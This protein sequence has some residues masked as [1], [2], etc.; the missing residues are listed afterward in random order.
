MS[1]RGPALC[2]LAFH[3][4]VD[5]RERDHD[6]S[7][8]SF[9]HLLDLIEDEVTSDLHLTK[10]AGRGV[11]LSFDD[12]TEDHAR[13]GAALA[14][15]GLR[16]L[17]FVPAGL[18]GSHGFLSDDG[19]RQLAAQYHTIGSHGLSN[20]RLDGLEPSALRREV[21]GST[22][23]LQNVI[24][25]EVA[26]FSP[27][28]GSEHPLLTEELERAGCTASRSMRWGI[29]RSEAERWRIP[30]VPVTE[31]TIGRGWV[32]AALGQFALPRT[33]RV[34]GTAKNLIPAGPRT[35]IRGWSH[36]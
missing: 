11:V 1:A 18:V 31:L 13:V 30:C 26:Y 15:R 5:V 32:E 34:V 7:W 9:E 19:V 21:Q 35:T 24:G 6:V 2:V 3:R 36:R 20:V 23:K 16:G 10:G 17:F 12:G 29:H 25:T 28:G 4:V 8:P 22:A 33:M 27:V 14:E